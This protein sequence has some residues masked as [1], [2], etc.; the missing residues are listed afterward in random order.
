MRPRIR[1][2]G[3]ILAILASLLLAAPAAAASPWTTFTQSGT[4]ASAD[5][6]DCRENP[7]GT[8]TCE[9]QSVYV[10]KGTMKASGEPTRKGEQV[11]YSEFSYTFDPSTGEFLDDEG[12]FG[13]TLDA[14]TLTVDNLTS[15]ALAPTV[16]ELTAWDCD[17]FGCV[18]TSA[19]S[20]TVYGTWTGIGPI[21]SH[22][23]RST[24]DDGSCIQVYADRGSMR[25]ASFV[26]SFDAEYAQISEGRFTFRTTCTWEEEF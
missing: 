24:F 22:K 7:D 16:V 26:G 18:E 17:E 25:E 19:G 20:T 15:I 2:A 6:W 5:A 21:M 23:G 1:P 8:E 9:N 14:G 12:V 3:I 11:C 4:T 10:F 13:C